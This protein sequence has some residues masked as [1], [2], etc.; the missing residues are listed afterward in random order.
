MSQTIMPMSSGTSPVVDAPGY[1]PDA[2]MAGKM[3]PAIY[4]SMS[5]FALLGLSAAFVPIGGAII[6][7]GQLSVDSRVKQVAHPLGGTVAEIRVQ[8]GQHVRKG[9]VLIR[10]DDRVSGAEATLSTLSADQLLAQKA[11]LEAE[12][13]GAQSIAFPVA[14]TN[15]A[16]PSARGAMADERRLFALRRTEQAGMA[17]QLQARIFQAEQEIAGYQ[18][19]IASL[20]GQSDLLAAERA[21]V[22]SLYERK[23]VTIARYNQLE[24]QAVDIGGSVASLR[25]QIA[26]TRGRIA[27]IRQQLVQL[28]ESRRSEAGS[29]LATINGQLNQQQSRSIAA[30]DTQDHTTIRATQS[31]VV[32]K[33]GVSTI[34]GVVRPAETILAIVPDDGMMVVECTISPTDIDQVHVGQAARVRFSALGSSATPELK[35]QVHYI[36]ADSLVDDKSGRRYFPI[37]VTLNPRATR[38]LQSGSLKQGLPAEI[39]IETGDRTMLSYLTKPLRDQFARSFRGD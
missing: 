19:Q 4:L 35:G 22:R 5:L 11:R 25:T 18:A 10:L 1:D 8:N 38:G 12:Q 28:G 15:N 36:G 9:D 23:L 14:L 17:T 32:E 30:L 39:F 6:G 37:R 3:R 13:A 20:N 7:A 24:R 33:L 21:G 26:A 31:G 2:E 27:E 16:S 29:Q 34:G